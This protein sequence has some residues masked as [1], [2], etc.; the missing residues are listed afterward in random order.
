MYVTHGHVTTSGSHAAH[1]FAFSRAAYQARFFFTPLLNTRIVFQVDLMF[2]IGSQAVS[3]EPTPP[4]APPAAPSA[5]A[6]ITGGGAPAGARDRAGSAASAS[7]VSTGAPGNRLGQVRREM[8]ALWKT[9]GFWAGLWSSATK[10]RRLPC[11]FV[12]YEEVVQSGVRRRAGVGRGFARGGKTRGSS[13]GGL[14]YICRRSLSGTPSGRALVLFFNDAPIYIYHF[15]R[16][17]S[18]R[19]KSS[20]F[21]SYHSRHHLTVPP[22]SPLWRTQR[23]LASALGVVASRVEAVTAGASSGFGSLAGAAATLTGAGD[24]GSGPGVVGGGGG[25]M[26]PELMDDLSK[27]LT[28]VEMKGIIQL[29]ERG[30]RMEA[31]AG[32]LQAEKEDLF[33]RLQVKPRTLTRSEMNR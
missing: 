2:G 28:T 30:R 21:G 16:H 32:A 7:S 11:G 10:T 15:S 1:A 31:R 25:G 13:G 29:T 4:A 17:V 3:A 24:G 19:T 6:G 9:E 26:S 23:A 5:A 27:R 22:H 20:R 14:V 12:L 8:F 33:A 18:V